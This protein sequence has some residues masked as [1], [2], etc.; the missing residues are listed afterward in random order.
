MANASTSRRRQSQKTFFA[1]VVS[2]VDPDQSTSLKLPSSCINKLFV[3][4]KKK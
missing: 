3:K 4:K 1:R 2:I